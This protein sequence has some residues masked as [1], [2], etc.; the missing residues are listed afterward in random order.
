MTE[1]T[2]LINP[3]PGLS[4]EKQRELLTRF[5]PNQWFVKEEFVVGRD[6]ELEDFFRLVRPARVVLVAFAGLLAD[7]RGR[8][9]DRIES[10]IVA[11][12]EI[13][14]RESYVA[15]YSGRDSRSHWSAMRKSGEEMC[16][17]LA[18]GSASVLN[19]KK[20]SPPLASLLSDQD[21][22]DLLRIK[23]SSEYPNWPRRRAE[24]RRLGIKP[25]P[26]RMWM[27]YQLEPAARARGLL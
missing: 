18:Q 10:M 9:I 17:R 20:G 13:H 25:I 8:K 26:S 1:Y 4:A 16:R 3:V 5:L 11:K 14:K 23:T 22:R 2:A 6:G 24:I 19:G 21:L 12:A 7:Q 15:E 27:T